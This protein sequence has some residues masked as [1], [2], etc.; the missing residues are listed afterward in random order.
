MEQNRNTAA[1]QRPAAD[2]PVQTRPNVEVGEF[3]ILELLFRLLA[4][5]K[6]LVILTVL[7][8]A[9]AFAYTQ[10]WITPMYRATSTVYV[11]NRKDSVINVSDLQIGT[12]LTKDYLEL[13]NTWELQEE[14]ISDLNLPYSYSYMKGHLSVTNPESTRM[15][16][17]SFTSPDPVEAANV[18]NAYA[19]LSRDFISEIMDSDKPNV[20][21]T[22]LTPSNPYNINRTRN[23]AMG[24]IGGLALAAGIVVIQMLLD[25]KIK[26]TE[27]IRR[28]TGL[29]NL[30]IVP[31]EEESAAA[32]SKR[33]THSSGKKSS[34][35]GGDSK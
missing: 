12:A 3:D 23:L 20:V 17:I 34:G 16:S 5:W 35:K 14:V 4:S 8:M 2:R 29:V 30:A 1:A 9:T 32:D 24:L 10:L 7:G 15:I 22:A 18:A 21:S 26:T 6:L 19:R 13:F 11:V 27:D 33:K 25:D 31:K 28:Y